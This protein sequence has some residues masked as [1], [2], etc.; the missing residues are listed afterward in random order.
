LILKTTLRQFNQIP[1]VFFITLSILLSL[2]TSANA[3]SVTLRWDPVVPTPGG[4]RIYVREAGQAYDYNDYAWS[5]TTVSCTLDNLD[6]LTDYY[7]VVRAYDKGVESSNSNEVHLAASISN[8]TASDTTSPSWNGATTGI[9]AV[10]DNRT[11]GSVTVEF[12]TAVDAVDGSDLKF[13]VYYAAS[14]S[15]K[16]GDWAN[17]K[18]VAD[19]A[20][21][22]GSTF[23][24]AVTVS[25]L[26]ND[27]SYTFGVRAEDQSGNEDTNTGTLKATPTRVETASAYNL[28]LSTNSNRS[29]AVYLDDS[30]IQGKIYVYVTPTTNVKKVEFFIDGTLKQTEN[31]APFD[32]AGSASGGLAAPFNADQL[33][34]GYHTFSAR[35]TLTNGSSETI[36]AEAHLYSETPVPDPA[37]ENGSAYTQWV[38][39]AANRANPYA[40][41]GASVSGKIYVFV[42]PTTNVKKVEFFIDGAL[43]QTESYAPYD[44]AGSASGGLAA[45]FNADQLT[46][47]YHT[48]SARITLTNG[49]RETISAE[50]YFSKDGETPV[51]SDPASVYTQWV[52]TTANRANP[53]ALDG[54]SVSGKIYVFVTPTTNVK[55]VEF[56]IDGALKQTESYAPYDLAGSASGG[57]AAPFNTGALKNGNHTFSARITTTSGSRETI[58]ADVIVAN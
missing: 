57:L 13:N 5:G 36:S 22:R 17:N 24:H 53:Y 8:N 39:T 3:A 45:P 50:A 44:L 55:K 34:S 52:S 38:S 56:F 40:L 20:T 10:T 28:M 30:G 41:D 18:V 16:S 26:T 2:F 32:M 7:F 15:W 27:V 11:G 37:A 9:G 21:K 48:F 6:P 51:I 49:S 58:V 33:T 19:A 46:S 42:T 29:G 23:D 25:G 43:K 35:I 12:D 47:G 54:A 31:N 4:Y 1:I 14:G